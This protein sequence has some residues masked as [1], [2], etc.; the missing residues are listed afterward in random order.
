MDIVL[1]TAVQRPENGEVG[2]VSVAG[3]REKVEAIL[4][5]MLAGMKKR[6]QIAYGQDGNLLDS[7]DAMMSASEQTFVD[8]LRMTVEYFNQ[9]AWTRGILKIALAAGHKLLGS[10]WTFGPDAA[11]FRQ[12]VMNS[13]ANWPKSSPRG[14]IAGE[15]DRSVRLALG[16]TATVRDKYQ[17]TVAV[18]PMSDGR[19]GAIAVSLFGGNG[20]P[21]AMFPIG[22]LPRS[23]VDALNSKAYRDTVMG[24]RVDPQTRITVPITFGE[25]DRRVTAR[26]PSNSRFRNAHVGRS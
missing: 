9:E 13:R 3:S 14:F 7:L 26:G 1:D 8:S 18:M 19:R 25:I 21:E 2:P 11:I 20:V 16:K 5:G 10:D 22:D 6:N 23:F 15:L 17:H 12:I 24:Y 4:Q